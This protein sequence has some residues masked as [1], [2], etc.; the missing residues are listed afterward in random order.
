MT[1]RVLVTGATGFVGS[2]AAAA[3]LADPALAVRLM[4]RRTA[5]DAVAPGAGSRAETVYGD[6]AVPA[7]LRGSCDGV[8]VLVHCASQIGGAEA[9]AVAVN[10]HGTRALV[11]EAVRSG[12][13]RI[14]LLSTAAV[15]GGG[16][17]TRLAPGQRTVAATSV[18]SRT[19][20]AAEQHV[21]AAGGVVLRPHLVYGVGDRWVVPGLVALLG[22]P[23]SGPSRGWTSRHSLIEVG[24]LGRALLAAGLAPARLSGVRHV[25][26]PVPVSCSELLSAI[27]DGLGH[28]SAPGGGAGGRAP[29]GAEADPTRTWS[30]DDPRIRHHLGMLAVDHW[31][32]DDRLWDDLGCA[33]GAGFAV[34][35]PRQLPWYRQFLARSEQ[36]P[37]QRA[38]AAAQPGSSTL[39]SIG[40]IPPGRS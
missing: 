18:T 29:G 40:S 2:R 1:A 17:F 5:P 19:R 25:N 6:L 11:A 38:E 9:D 4:T 36:R 15:Y 10:D 14:V 16:P 28:G 39:P 23:A 13:Q 33:P 35:F 3:A 22:T 7:S 37:E 20:A 21:L 30:A 12:V 26:H 27:A 31:F 24:V 34:D 32:A 8:D